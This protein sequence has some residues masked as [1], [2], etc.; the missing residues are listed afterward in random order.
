MPNFISFISFPPESYAIK[1]LYLKRYTYTKILKNYGS[2]AQLV[3]KRWNQT[4]AR[5]S[6]LAGRNFSEFQMVFCLTES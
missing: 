2:V 6:S 4:C 1:K 5:G 3:E